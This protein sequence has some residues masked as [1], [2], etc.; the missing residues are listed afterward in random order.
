MNKNKK[1]VVALS[2]ATIML[3][4]NTMPL[5]AKNN[6]E[7]KWM[8]GEYHTHT[9]QSKDAGEKITTTEHIL[10]CSI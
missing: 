10:D 1:F 8:S 7:G 4:Q 5:L 3:M 6:E 9:T 2:L